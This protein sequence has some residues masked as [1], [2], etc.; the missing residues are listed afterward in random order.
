[1]SLCVCLPPTYLPTYLLPIQTQALR[2]WLGG[3]GFFFGLLGLV[4]L[5][6]PGAANPTVNKA[7]TMPDLGLSFIKTGGSPAAE[8]EEEEAEAEE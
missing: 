5:T 4:A 2:W 3:F 7:E 6:D 1:M 8:E